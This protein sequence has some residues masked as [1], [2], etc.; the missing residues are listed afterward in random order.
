LTT[1]PLRVGRAAGADPGR[2]VLVERLLRDAVRVLPRAH[3]DGDFAFT[4]AGT[5]PGAPGSRGEHARGGRWRVRP[6]GTS[7]RYAAITALGLMRVPEACQ[8]QILGGADC[9]D[10]VGRLAKR[11]DAL[12]STGDVALICWAAAECGHGELAHALARLRDLD[13]GG[14]PLGVVA[15]AWVVT[16]LVAA[17][18]GHDVE[19][20][21]AV[22]RHRLLTARL[23]VYPHTTS[24]SGGWYRSHVGSFADQVY[25]VQAL[26]RLHASDGDLEALAV[27]NQVAGVICHAQGEAG[28]WWW[29]YDSRTGSVVEGYP[30]YSVHQHAMAPMALFDLA[31]AGGNDHLASVCRGL[32]WLSDPPETAEDLVP[33]DPVPAWRNVMR[34]DTRKVVRGVRA[35]AT[36]VRPGT[37]LPALDRLFPPGAVD[38]EC[39]PY[40]LG[41]LLYAWM[42][43]VSG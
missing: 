38:H 34:Q 9:H 30:V 41:W 33:G 20:H 32:G 25:P 17:R 3:R 11:L 6:V 31:E 21:L 2:A 24:G 16:A 35:A 4:L 5:R 28:Q 26:A 13:D 23:A 43:G 39:R 37:R 36:R 12:T 14:N 10:L 42:P 18:A 22:A 8:R 40:E 27:A 15:A 19:R 29:H 7:V 1:P